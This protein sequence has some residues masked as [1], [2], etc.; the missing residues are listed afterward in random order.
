MGNGT[1]RIWKSDPT[2]T[3]RCPVAT[4]RPP[5][6]VPQEWNPFPR[7]HVGISTVSKAVFNF[8]T[9]CFYKRLLLWALSYLFSTQQ[10]HRNLARRTTKG[11]VQMEESPTL[12]NGKGKKRSQTSLSLHYMTEIILSTEDSQ[13]SSLS[14]HQLPKQVFLQQISAKSTWWPLT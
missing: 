9:A 12:A 13:L 1:Q 8:Y 11:S 3:S 6:P 5:S 14:W 2:F 10:G 4:I 7:K